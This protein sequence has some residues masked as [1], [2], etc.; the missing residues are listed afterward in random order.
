MFPWYFVADT[1]VSDLPTQS[2][3]YKLNKIINHET[4]NVRLSS[5]VNPYE[6]QND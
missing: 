1:K 3:V 5:A 6:E 4:K 2:A